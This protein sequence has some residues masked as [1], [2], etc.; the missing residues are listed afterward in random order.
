MKIL[1]LTTHPP[2]HPRCSH[3]PSTNYFGPTPKSSKDKKLSHVVYS[4]PH[5]LR[6]FFPRSDSI[7]LYP[8][9]MLFCDFFLLTTPEFSTSWPVGA[10]KRTGRVVQFKRPRHLPILRLPTSV[11]ISVIVPRPTITCTFHVY[12]DSYSFV[13]WR[14]LY[15][16]YRWV[17]LEE[18]M[19][20]RL[21]F[22]YLV[23]FKKPLH[24]V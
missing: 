24:F 15:V 9:D 14:T 6:R 22:M 23:S 20:E 5:F 12:Y 11:F 21:K 4:R 13:L 16:V 18:L 10:R 19:I 8:P 1:P 3:A 17:G 7:V 2:L